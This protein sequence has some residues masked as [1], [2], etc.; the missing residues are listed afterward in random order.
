MEAQ[1]KRRILFVDDDSA[2]VELVKTYLG[3]WYQVETASTGEEAVQACL[4]KAPDLVL[5]DLMMPGTP[6]YEGDE[7]I[8]RITTD[9]RTSTIPIIVQTGFQNTRVLLLMGQTPNIVGVLLKPFDLAMLK[10]KIQVV[11]GAPA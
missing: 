3:K 11:L 9:P 5:M 1:P 8:R 7:A 10:K 4:T 2:A 6:S